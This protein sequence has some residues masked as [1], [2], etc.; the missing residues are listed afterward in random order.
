MLGG[1]LA[2]LAEGAGSLFRPILPGATL[3]DRLIACCG[4]LLGIAA[5]GLLCR[6]MLAYMSSAPVLVA[7]MGASAVLL[8]AVPASPLAQPWSI[9]GGNTLSAIVGVLVAAAIPDPMLAGAAAVALAIATMSLTRCLHPPGGAAAL[10]AVLGGP[11]VTELGIKFA[12]FPVAVNSI[13]LMTAGLMFH[14]LSG[15][16]YPHRPA[17]IH[18]TGDPPPQLRPAITGNDLDDALR[19]LTEALDVSRDDLS[20]LLVNAEL[21]ALERLNAEITCRDVMSRDVICVASDSN[22]RIARTRLTEH[23]FRTLPVIDAQNRVVGVVGHE[24]LSHAE[25]RNGGSRV[26]DV[27]IPAAV[28][29]PD[30][31]VFRLLGRLSDG[32]THDVVIVDQ[33]RRL[34]GVVTQTDLLVVLARTALLRAIRVDD[35]EAGNQRLRLRDASAG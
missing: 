31:P 21:H 32:R 34:L 29:L 24:Q 2:A 23:G 6:N 13:L 20:A 17:N 22:P 27:M 19:N 26:A 5:T 4:A 30:V 18:R 35:G 11:A 28:E 12:F 14:R 10:T 15:H 9:V 25:L 33:D 16:S 1:R 8:F 3:R 7:P